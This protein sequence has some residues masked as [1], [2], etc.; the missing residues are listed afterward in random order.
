MSESGIQN[1]V[2]VCLLKFGMGVFNENLRSKHSLE[3]REEYHQEY[4]S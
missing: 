2:W 4:F 1:L 3:K